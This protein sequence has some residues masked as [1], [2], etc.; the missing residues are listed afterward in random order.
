MDERDKVLAMERKGGYE[1]KVEFVYSYLF[2]CLIDFEGRIDLKDILKDFPA[3][4]EELA[5]DCIELLWNSAQTFYE[6]EYLENEIINKKLDVVV[7]KLLE[8]F[9]L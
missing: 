1:G 5:I 2:A 8:D 3:L 9:G 6:N 7:E 4:E